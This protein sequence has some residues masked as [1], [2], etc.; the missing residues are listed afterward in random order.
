MLARSVT[1]LAVFAAAAAAAGCLAVGPYATVK[2]IEQFENATGA[3]LD[4]TPVPIQPTTPRL[5]EAGSPSPSTSGSGSSSPGPDA[6]PSGAPGASPSPAGTA[7]STD[8]TLITLSQFNQVQN[9]MT[10]A[11]VVAIFGRE[12]QL[13]ANSRVPA[14]V[15]HNTN[16]SLVRVIFSGDRVAEKEQQRLS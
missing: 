16:G 7:P 2:V 11:E 14:Y 8:P 3:R 12:G 9:G 4:P 10:Y 15:W 5:G 1:F 13:L 6:G